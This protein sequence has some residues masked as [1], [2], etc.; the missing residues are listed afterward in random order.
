VE[1]TIEESSSSDSNSDSD[2]PEGT[3]KAKG[4][5]S[6]LHG[7][8]AKAGHHHHHRRRVT[9][10]VT[11]YADAKDVS[12]YKAGD[13]AAILGQVSAFPVLA[14]VRAG[15]DGSDSNS[16]VAVP[17]R[18]FGGGGRAGDGVYA[19][20]GADAAGGAGAGAGAGEGSA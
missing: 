4:K 20:G 18:A 13:L 7:S 17:G 19:E 6:E 12:S 11:K 14:A 16:S 2:S 1:E 10:K 3:R 9:H 8:P 5:R 15:G